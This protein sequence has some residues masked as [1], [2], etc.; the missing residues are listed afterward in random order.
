V[1]ELR[2]VKVLW[3][4]YNAMPT[5]QN[6]RVSQLL[7]RRTR[8]ARARGLRTLQ[9]QALARSTL[10]AIDAEIWL[11][12][13]IVGR[14]HTE[15]AEQTRPD[16]AWA[17]KDQIHDEALAWYLQQ[18]GGASGAPGASARA[19]APAASAAARTR[20]RGPA[21]R[22]RAR[23]T[24]RQLTHEDVTFW[25]DSRLLARARRL[26]AREGLRVA[27]LIE[28]ALD[29]YIAAHIPVDVVRFHRRAQAQALRLHQRRDG[30]AAAGTATVS[31]GDDPPGR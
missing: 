23:L 2:A 18:P 4:E 27:Q 17:T 19:G 28:R 16:P 29:G 20:R 22:A 6:G 10:A 3:L 8:S 24:S 5:R 30:G 31:A 14:T 13:L 1:P 11:R 9:H 26:A 12:S 25:V 15:A 7:G 21:G